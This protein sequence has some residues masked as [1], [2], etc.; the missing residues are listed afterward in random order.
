MIAAL[1]TEMDITATV[2]AS[3]DARPPVLIQGT[4]IAPGSYEFTPNLSVRALLAKAGAGGGTADTALYRALDAR[5]HELRTLRA[6]LMLRHARLTAQRAGAQ[7]LNLPADRLKSL[8]TQLGLDRVNGETAVLQAALDETALRK[9]RDIAIRADLE[10][11]LKIAETRR[12]LV[13]SRYEHISRQRDELE[14][15]IGAECRGQCGSSR[16]Y[17]ELR[18]D[19]L[20]GRLSDFDLTVEEAESRVIA[21]RHALARHDRDVAFAYAQADSKL[22][23][24]A[25]ETLAERNALD[26]EIVSVEA[27]IMDLGGATERS[28]RVERRQGAQ[29]Q[30]LNVQRDFL[31]LPGDLILVGPPDDA[32]LASAQG[33]RE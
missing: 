12:Q 24:S 27:Q 18:L 21:S 7:D 5:S 13:R 15:D 4:V 11:S 8:H 17:D 3:F 16:R 2:T 6:G 30:T 32:I 14:V 29:I 9:A 23:L 33:R 1:K 28:I 22:A 31:L 25:A 10:S 20:N 19:N 26:A